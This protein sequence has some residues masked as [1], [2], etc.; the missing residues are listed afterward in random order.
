MIFVRINRRCRLFFGHS[1]GTVRPDQARQ[2]DKSRAVNWTAILLQ[3][4]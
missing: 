4:E 3:G 1:I 2:S